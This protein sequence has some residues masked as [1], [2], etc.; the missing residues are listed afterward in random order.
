METNIHPYV[1]AITGQDL[2]DLNLHGSEWLCKW[3]AVRGYCLWKIFS[4]TAGCCIN[5]ITHSII[6]GGWDGN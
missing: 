6:N 4:L 2:F 3:P 5:N 1:V